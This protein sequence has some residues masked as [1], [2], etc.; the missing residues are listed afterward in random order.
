MGPNGLNDLAPETNDPYVDLDQGKADTVGR[1]MTAL[2][3]VCKGV[4]L[5]RNEVA[6]KP[7]ELEDDK[8]IYLDKL[9]KLLQ[10]F[11]ELTKKVSGSQYPTLNRAMSVYNKLI[12]QLEDVIANE[13]DPVLKQATA[14]GRTKLLKYY[15]KMDSTPVY[16]VATAMDPVAVSGNKYEQ[17]ETTRSSTESPAEFCN[18]G[19]P[20]SGSS[21][22]RQCR[23]NYENR[24]NGDEVMLRKV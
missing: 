1:G 2:S 6:L 12:D 24:Y 13:E 18:Q 15:V 20:N 19:G 21:N 8:W 14:Q 9:A 10:Q 3:K 7:Y 17:E 5:I 22:E 23:E 11:N 4:V 16:M